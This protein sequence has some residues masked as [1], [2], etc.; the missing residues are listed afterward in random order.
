[1]STIQLS[2]IQEAAEAKYGDLKIETSDDTLV[3]RNVLRLSK[4][5][6][7]EFFALLDKKGE[8]ED[9]AAEDVEEVFD[10]AF[11]VVATKAH[12]A[13]LAKFDAPMKAVIFE[14]YT[15]ATQ[16]GEASGSQN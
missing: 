3:L 9:A 10:Q 14:R 4:E 1:M 16:S 15:E 6:R 12:A 8:D 11:A 13:E 7:K 2:D 5:A